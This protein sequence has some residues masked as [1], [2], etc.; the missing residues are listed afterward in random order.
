MERPIGKRVVQPEIEREELRKQQ[1]GWSR[2]L[3]GTLSQEK[4]AD[5]KEPIGEK[6]GKDCCRHATEQE[7]EEGAIQQISLP[8]HGST[9]RRQECY[10]RKRDQ[11]PTPRRE[12]SCSVGAPKSH[13]REKRRDKM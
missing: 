10:E 3:G 2:D 13:A 7:K 1:I 8:D 6:K 4:V 5:K 11:S 9:D 12:K